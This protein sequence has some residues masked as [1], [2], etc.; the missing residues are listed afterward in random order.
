MQTH[1]ITLKARV[2]SLE[3]EGIAKTA[4]RFYLD[5]SGRDIKE[6]DKAHLLLRE[7]EES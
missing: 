6:L 4:L 3:E 5:N 2:F 7:L 1:E